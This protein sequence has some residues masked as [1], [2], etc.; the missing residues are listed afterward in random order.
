MILHDAI[1]RAQAQASSFADGLGG[2]E[3]VEYAMRLSY[4]GA[5]IRKLHH[6]LLALTVRQ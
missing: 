2:V 3:G 4:A 5:G 1:H 6:H